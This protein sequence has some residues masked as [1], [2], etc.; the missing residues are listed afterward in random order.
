MRRSET[1]A[2][3]RHAVE[4]GEPALAGE[5]LERAGGFRLWLREG[6]VQFQAADRWLGEDVIEARP[7]LALVRCL[8]SVLSGRLE[9]ARERYRSMAES[10]AARLGGLEAEASDADVELAVDNS[11]VRGMLALYGGERFGSELTRTLLADLAQLA[12]SPR[13]DVLT[14]G[15]LEHGLCIASNISAEFGAALEHAAR[16]RQCF[17]ESRYMTMYID[18]QVG[19]IAMAQGRVQNA[20]AHYRRAQRVANNNYVLDALP[21]AICGVLSQ[22]LALECNRAA[23]GAGLARVPGALATGSSPFSTYAAAAGAVVELRLRD[24]GV[25]GA[26]AAA[27]EM[28]DYVRKARLP[29]LVRYVSALRVSVLAIAGRIGDGEAAWALDD[30]PEEA[31]DCLD[32]AGQSWREMEALSCAR[33]RLTIGR[34]RFEAARGFADKL[35]AVAAARGLRR[36]L[37]RGLSLSV[38]LEHRAGETAATAGHLEA[39]LRLYARDALRMAAGAGAR[40]LRAAGGRIPRIGPGFSLQ[41][42]SAIASEGDGEGRRPPATDAERARVGGAATARGTAGQGDRCRAGAERVWCALSHPQAVHQAGGAQSGRGDAPGAGDGPGSG[43]VLSERRRR[44]CPALHRRDR[45]GPGV[46]A[47]GPRRHASASP[48]FPARVDADVW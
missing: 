12:E 1:V 21:T 48:A 26:L 14:R 33:L 27:D 5:F 15:H 4:A 28:L 39:Y 8:A 31:A 32:L 42:D 23:P 25:D 43:R 19:Q 47:S 3:M 6:L 44:T 2:A 45:Q 36:T 20:E 22:E 35:R 11:V 34:A 24:E 10:V 18:V 17:S 9:E 16:A 38:V 29:A 41:G 30:L 13:V 7:R 40:G 37:M 46:P